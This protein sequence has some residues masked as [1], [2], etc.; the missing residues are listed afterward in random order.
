MEKITL[1]RL[2]ISQYLKSL[3]QLLSF[4]RSFQQLFCK[5]FGTSSFADPFLTILGA[6]AIVE[7]KVAQTVLLVYADII[8]RE[9]KNFMEEKN[10]LFALPVDVLAKN[11]TKITSEMRKHKIPTIE[12]KTTKAMKAMKEM[13]T[14]KTMK[15][16]KA[17]KAMKAMKMMKAMKGKKA[18]KAK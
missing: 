13:K 3:P 8:D 6:M 16:T 18:M 15:T 12:T 5:T 4:A 1:K 10:T 7:A 14:L 11:I 17:I 2:S 9:V